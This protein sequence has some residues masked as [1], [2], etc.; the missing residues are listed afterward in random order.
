MADAGTVQHEFDL[1][2][3]AQLQAA[4]LPKS[5]P[6]DCPNHVAAARNRMCAAIGGD[7]YD[8]LRL[9]DD[10]V[11]LVL[12]DVVGHGVRAALIMAQI[13]GFL[14]SQSATLSRPAETV[15][16]LNDMLVDLS[17]RVGAVLPCSL[18]YGVIDAHTGEAVFVNAGHMRPFVSD[19]QGS[20]S[21]QLGE[22]NLLL[23]VEEYAPTEARHTFAPGERLV[24]F[25][26]GVTEAT[27]PS[28]EQFDSARLHDVI[29]QQRTADADSCAEAVFHAVDEFR[30]G[31]DRTDDETIV[32]VDRV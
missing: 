19:R 1:A 22:T 8:F 25:T 27:D 30:Q 26:D 23:G 12:G 10:Q 17:R 3:A 14:R 9:D 20:K 11:A 4:L 2:L 5:C 16:A 13:M 28:G 32:V 15:A 7:F 6:R 18:I 24:M 29:Q 21:L 31:G